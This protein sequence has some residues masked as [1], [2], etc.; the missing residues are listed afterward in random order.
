MTNQLSKILRDNKS[1]ALPKNPGKYEG[2]GSEGLLPLGLK[3]SPR[4]FSTALIFN[5]DQFQMTNFL[6]VLVARVTEIQVP[7]GS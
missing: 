5:D 6:F 1:Y 2:G 7:Q 4:H 3:K